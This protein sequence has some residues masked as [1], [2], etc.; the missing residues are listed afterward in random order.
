MPDVESQ[1]S[2]QNDSMIL[3]G[4]NRILKTRIFRAIPASFWALLGLIILLGILSPRSLAPQNLLNLL[5]QGSA[6]GLLAIG[7]TIVMISGGLDFSI[8]SIVV[9]SDVMAAQMIN[10]HTERVLPVLL[11]V[12]SLG[13]VIGL[14]NGLIITKLHV[15]PFIATLG[16]QLI[17]YGAALIY[18]GGVPK[19]DIPSS[20]KFWGNGFVVDIIPVA[21]LIYLS[22]SIIAILILKRT[23]FGRRIFALGANTRA[24]Y[25]AGVNI[26]FTTI[27]A[28][29]I[30]GFTAAA[31]GLL[32]VAYVGVGTLN[33]GSTYLL[34]S[35]SAAIIGGSTFAGGK[36]TLLG[37][38]GGV[39]FLMTL[40]SILTV[41]HL[42]TSGQDIAEG[43]IIL[44]AIALYARDRE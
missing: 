10:G 31:G 25:V 4:L 24:A 42:P 36:G 17:V 35:I 7:Q 21:G 44:V 11:F 28:Y 8:G 14:I 39:L 29:V 6:L 41:I 23:V 12:L 20:M 18:S 1:K 38:I 40:N 22:I 27:L 30:C 15:A 43:L 34:G 5:R 16:M 19:G 3:R 26:S 2:P 9:L 32:L 33:V 13:A 37:T